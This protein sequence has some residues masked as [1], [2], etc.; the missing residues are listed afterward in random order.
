MDIDINRNNRRVTISMAG[1]IDKLFQTIRPNG[2]KG[3]ST[4]NSYVPPNYKKSGAQTA[5]IDDT[6]LATLAQKKEHQSVIGTLL[7]YSRTVDPSILTAVQ[8]SHH[9]GYA[10]NG[11]TIAISIHSQ[12]LWNPLLRIKYAVTSPIRRVLSQ[13][14]TRQV[15]IRG[16]ILF[17]YQESYQWISSLHE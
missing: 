1:Y 5:T 2:T 8:E 15:R 3:A 9:Q 6:P 14:T 12:K 11:T 10:K 16:P 13:Q 17:R 4:P 7:Y